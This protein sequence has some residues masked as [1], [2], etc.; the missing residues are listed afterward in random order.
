M[1]EKKIKHPLGRTDE[2]V[3]IQ[4]VLTSLASQENCDGEPYDEMVIAADY[5]DELEEMINGDVRDSLKLLISIT[6][7][8]LVDEVP[9]G[10]DPTMYI[11][12]SYKHDCELQEKVKGIVKRYN[13][14]DE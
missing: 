4:Y 3:P 2:L 1:I 10:L 11:T 14:K 8:L 12:N 7:N 13:L 9:E 5:I 6:G